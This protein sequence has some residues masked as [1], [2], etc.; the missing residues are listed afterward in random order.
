MNFWICGN[1][2]FHSGIKKRKFGTQGF[3]FKSSI[4][5]ESDATNEID[6]VIGKKVSIKQLMF[7]NQSF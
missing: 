4:S 3:C 7:K 1:Y 2:L 6:N 5:R